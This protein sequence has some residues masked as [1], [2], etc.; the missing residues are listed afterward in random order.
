MRPSK[1]AADEMRT[2]KITRHF[3]KHAEGS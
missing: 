2:I 1:R 3:T